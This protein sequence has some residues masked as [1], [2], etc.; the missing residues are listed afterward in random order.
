M[1]WPWSDDLYLRGMIVQPELFL[2]NKQGKPPFIGLCY[3]VGARGL[4]EVENLDLLNIPRRLELYAEFKSDSVTLRLQ[5]D[6]LATVRWFSPARYDEKKVMSWLAQHR[7][8]KQLAFGSVLK[9]ASGE[10]SAVRY[11]GKPVIFT[12][13]RLVVFWK[14]DSC[15]IKFAR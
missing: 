3:P 15:A 4:V 6:G 5:V 12:I 13:S 8:A 10:L 2:S 9:S 7:T 14:V 11:K 1:A